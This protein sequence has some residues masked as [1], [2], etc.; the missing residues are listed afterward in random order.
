MQLRDNKIF[1][2]IDIGTN[3]CLLL[4]ASLKDKKLTKLFET[5]KI[6]RLGKNLY[7]TGKIS[8]EAFHNTSAIIKNYISISEKY[9]SRK[10]FAFGTSALREAKNSSEFIKF[11]ESE[12]GVEIK[13]INGEAEAKYSYDGAVFDFDKR[14]EYAVIDIGGGSTEICFSDSGKIISKSIDVGSVRLYEEFF[15]GNFNKQNIEGA[16]KF[17]NA[18][19]HDLDFKLKDKVLLGVAGTMTTLSAIKNNLKE[20]KEEIIHK[21]T[22]TLDE[23]KNTL[24]K[25]ISMTENER[26]EIGSYMEGRSDIIICGA[27]ILKGVMEYFI[28]N[29][30]IVSAKGLRYGLL[31][32][33]HDFN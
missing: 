14:K 22:M 24:V 25:L 5:Q 26:M 2:V 7:K 1:S 27:L 17:I 20:F 15:E 28:L 32:N 18:N 9:N 16:G 30:V 3:T 29:K 21:E 23:I 33:L 19:L 8:E 12:T 4:I 10:I 6:P 11:V 13:V 31:L